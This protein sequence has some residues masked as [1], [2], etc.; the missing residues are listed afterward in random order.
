M[1]VTADITLFSVSDIEKK[2]YRQIDQKAF[3]I[4]LV[5]RNT[6]PF[7]GK[8]CLPGGFLSLDETLDSLHEAF[9]EGAIDEFEYDTLIDHLLS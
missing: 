3:S 5:K 9:T 6:P 2:N 4:L 8:W 1:S 7:M